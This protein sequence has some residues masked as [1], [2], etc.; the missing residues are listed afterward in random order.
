MLYFNS[1]IIIGFCNSI[2]IFREK[3]VLNYIDFYRCIEPIV[4]ILVN[5]THTIMFTVDDGAIN[6]VEFIIRRCNG[7]SNESI[8]KY[9]HILQLYLCVI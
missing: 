8:N 5:T 3:R 9:I 4:T 6:R 1:L 2:K 7:V